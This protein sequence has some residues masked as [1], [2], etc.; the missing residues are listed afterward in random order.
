MTTTSRRTARDIA[1]E[2]L[3]PSQQLKLRE[4]ADLHNIPDD[5][6]LYWM[7]IML[8]PD[9][10]IQQ[11]LDQGFDLIAGNMEHFT[12][13]LI[14]LEQLCQRKT[15]GT[16]TVPTPH[17]WLLALLLSAMGAVLGTTGFI[18]GYQSRPLAPVPVA[19][20]QIETV[21]TDPSS[22][23]AEQSGTGLNLDPQLMKANQDR[24]KLCL[25]DGNSKCTFLVRP[26]S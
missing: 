23:S 1:L 19:A 15:E 6:S 5:D 9:A 26:E 21:A 3:T 20:G 18:W 25:A 10:Q 12:N 22:M 13:R 2:G 24:L 11:Q 16:A 7:S 17:P 8:K 14:S 4:L